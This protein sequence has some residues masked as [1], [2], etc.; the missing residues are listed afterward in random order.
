MKRR[1]ADDWRRTVALADAKLQRFDRVNARVWFSSKDHDRNE[2]VRRLEDARLRLLEA[3]LAEQA[4]TATPAV[5][6]HDPPT[7]YAARQIPVVLEQWR[8]MKGRRRSLVKLAQL[9]GV[10]RETLADWRRRGWLVL[11]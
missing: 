10:D 6:D 8:A 3:E 11:D 4:P 9:T 2:L 7:D 1:T 5:H